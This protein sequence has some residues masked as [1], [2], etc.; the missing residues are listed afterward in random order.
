M[1]KILKFKIW[2]DYAHFKKFYTTTSPL[3]FEFPPP[4]TIIGIIS[5]II[6]LDK[7]EYLE[8]FQNPDDSK[9]SLSIVNSIKKVR[10][11]QNLIDTKHHFWRIKNRTQIRIEFLKDSAFTIYFSHKNEKIYNLLKSNLENHKT[12]Y[13]I[14]LGLSE[15]LADF[16]FLGEIRIDRIQSN[17]WI[18]IDSILP[19]SYLIDEAIDFKV[20]REIFKVNFPILM[21]PN[22]VVNKREDILFERNGKPIKCKVKEFWKTEEGENIVFF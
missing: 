8:H 4:P 11:T 13:S 12:I 19:Y 6:G 18:D 21:Q 7:N 9:I 15:L 17:E 5:A 1:D 16:E 14:S 20:S 3:T 10:W 22:R 2:G